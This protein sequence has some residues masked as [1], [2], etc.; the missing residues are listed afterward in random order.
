MKWVIYI[1]QNSRLVANL[2][3]DR[4]DSPLGVPVHHVREG[5]VVR[6]SVDSDKAVLLVLQVTAAIPDTGELHSV[7]LFSLK[8]QRIDNDCTCY[9]YYSDSKD[10]LNI[11]HVQDF[12]VG[13]EA[14]G[15]RGWSSKLVDKS[16]GKFGIL[17]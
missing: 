17:I 8:K 4:C 9:N 11:S 2:C 15:R 1:V 6:W 7:F 16:Y 14:D 12:C 10:S 13:G 5:I 3:H